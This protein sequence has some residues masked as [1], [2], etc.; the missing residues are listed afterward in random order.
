MV[1]RNQIKS[2]QIKK[3]QQLDISR[4]RELEPE[5]L[6]PSILCRCSHKLD[7]VMSIDTLLV[8]SVLESFVP[9]W[10]STF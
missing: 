2:N 6:P 1:L 4:V 3:P 9:A 5:S 8:T 7:K 10:M